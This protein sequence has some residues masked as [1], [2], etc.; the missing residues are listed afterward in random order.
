[1]RRSDYSAN[2]P[3]AWDVISY[4][5]GRGVYAGG[6]DLGVMP[7]LMNCFRGKTL[8]CPGLMKSLTHSSGAALPWITMGE[9]CH[10]VAV[11]LVVIGIVAACHFRRAVFGDARRAFHQRLS[12]R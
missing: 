7:Y 12:E 1:M 11:G 3:L 9:N 6:C 4:R 10:V 8:L 2:P 5:T